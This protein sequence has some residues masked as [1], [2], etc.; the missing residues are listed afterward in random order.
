MFEELGQ[1]VSPL[2]L[3]ESK[4]CVNVCAP[5][6]RYSKLPFR[7][8]VRGYDVD[9]CYTPMILSA[10]FAASKYARDSELTTN[11]KDT[12]LVIQFAAK[13]SK[14]LSDAAELVAKYV[15]GIDINCGCPQ[16][17]AIN[18]GIGARLMEKPEFVRDMV[19]AVKSRVGTEVTCSVKI[20]VHADLRQVTKNKSLLETVSFVQQVE[21]TGLDFIAVHG[22]TRRQRSSEP[23]NLDAIKLVKETVSIP[24]IANGDVF[25]VEDAQRIQSYTGVDGVMSARGILENPALFSGHKRTPWACVEKFV[26][27]SLDYGNNFFIFHHHLIYMLEKVMSN[28]ESKAFNTLTNTPA[29]LDYLEEHYGLKLY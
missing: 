23:V 24:V 2:T 9:L 4:R 25:S 5:M 13:N 6:V 26:R 11:I 20:R 29:V 15:S 18:E 22:R 21:S 19:R 12:P 28:A 10:D 1:K 7:E 8:L 16:K 3:F 14:E 27:L 17:W